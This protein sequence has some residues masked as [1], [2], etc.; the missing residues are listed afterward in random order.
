M[1]NAWQSFL[2]TLVPVLITAIV[3]VGGGGVAMWKWLQQQ[4]RKRRLDEADRQSHDADVAQVATDSTWKRATEIMDRDRDTIK[5]IS[6][7]RDDCYD[8]LTKQRGAKLD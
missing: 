2:S 8:T 3:A 1:D 7:E 5:R 4:E 6:K